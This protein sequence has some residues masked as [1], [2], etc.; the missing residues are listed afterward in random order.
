MTARTRTAIGRAPPR[1]PADTPINRDPT[2]L[3]KERQ[4]QVEY[5]DEE[6]PA[7]TIAHNRPHVLGRE[8]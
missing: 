6:L 8:S 7:L 5:P 3:T 1:H 4:S 2:Q